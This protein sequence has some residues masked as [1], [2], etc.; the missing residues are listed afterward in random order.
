MYY[1]V[2]YGGGV[3]WVFS[4]EPWAGSEGVLKNCVK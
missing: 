3:G 1:E 2:H 4:S